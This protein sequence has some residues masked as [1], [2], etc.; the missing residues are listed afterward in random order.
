MTPPVSAE[1]VPHRAG[2]GLLG[3]GV[4]P[5]AWLAALSGLVCA[6]FSTTGLGS[7]PSN[8][9]QRHLDRMAKAAQTLNYDGTFVYRNGA[10]IQSMRIIHRFGSDGERERLVALSGAAREVLRDRERVTCILPDSHS[11]VVAKS[12]PRTFPHSKLFES[13]RRFQ[14]YYA[15]SVQKGERIAGRHTELVAVAPLDRFRYGY[16]LWMDRDTGLLLKSELID[17]H[18]AI[19]EQIVYTNIELPATISDELL[20]PEISGAGYTWYR[21]EAPAPSSSPQSPGASQ[22][23]PEWLPD[24]FELHDHAHNPIVE[25]RE[26]VEHMVF[27]DG[28]ASL[29]VFIERLDST[30]RPLD[31]P[32]SMGALNAY[33][34]MVK[35]FQVTVVGEVPGATVERVALSIM[36]P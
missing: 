18:D 8:L 3:D 36:R 10:T 21:D 9:P 2:D 27:S 28:L 6:V 31:G 15:M 35:G 23:S 30:A 17:E 29:S 12:R 20:E 32:S 5:R 11:V 22:W 1:P 26:P 14:R 13:D 25:G 24:G 19:V 33:G 34:S 7:E 4:A 16:R